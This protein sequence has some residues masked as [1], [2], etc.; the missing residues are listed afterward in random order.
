MAASA[1]GGDAGM[2]AAARSCFSDHRFDGG[3]ADC[4]RCFVVPWGAWSVGCSSCLVPACS[5]PCVSHSPGRWDCVFLS[6][7]C[8]RHQS[9]RGV[10][11]VPV[12]GE[13]R[14]RI[15]P[16]VLVLVLI[17]SSSSRA[18]REVVPVVLVFRFISSV[19]SLLIWGGYRAADGER[20]LSSVLASRSY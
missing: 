19:S 2:I 5:W 14:R 12:V 1:A 9:R 20:C 13:P 6:C 16:G 15:C 11:G 7:S 8:L 10:L 18:A 4:L 3:T 17:I